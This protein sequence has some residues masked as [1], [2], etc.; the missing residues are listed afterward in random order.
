MGRVKAWIMEDE[1]NLNEYV[2]SIVSECKTF[3]EFAKKVNR[4]IYNNNI[5]ILGFYADGSSTSGF[6][7]DVWSER[8]EKT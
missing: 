5:R 8:N 6:L 2:W 4:Y 3:K 7:S 1:E